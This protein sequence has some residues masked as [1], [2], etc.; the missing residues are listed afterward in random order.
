[1]SAEKTKLR[2]EIRR[3]LLDCQAC[4]WFV[5]VRADLD[6]AFDAMN[7]DDIWLVEDVVQHE[8]YTIARCDRCSSVRSYYLVLLGRIKCPGF[9]IRKEQ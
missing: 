8:G 4:R 1:M 3:R 7:G 6:R 5:G 9:Q 2:D